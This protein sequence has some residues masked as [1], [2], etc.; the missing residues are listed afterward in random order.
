MPH[1]YE[2]RMKMNPSAT[3]TCI[4]QYTRIKRTRKKVS[5]VTTH[6]LPRFINIVF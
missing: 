4:G 6:P 5:L 2:L 1:E 3:D